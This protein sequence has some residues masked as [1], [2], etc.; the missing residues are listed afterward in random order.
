[1]TQLR[2]VLPGIPAT[3]PKPEVVETRNVR[4]K[5]IDWAACGVVL[6]YCFTAAAQARAAIKSEIF[7][8]P[9]R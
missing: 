5:K 3:T 6:L 1:M 4:A 2:K 7:F 8:I 9:H